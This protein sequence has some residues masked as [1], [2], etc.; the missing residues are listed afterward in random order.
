MTE[1]AP[2]LDQWRRL[3]QLAGRLKELAPWEWMEEIDLFGVQDPERGTLN[4]VG[5]MGLIKEHFAL[6]LYLGPQSLHRFIELHRRS[7][8]PDLEELLNT[9]QLQLSFEDRD[10]V[11]KEDRQVL[12]Q[13]GLS[14]RG[15]NS[16]PLWRSYRPG[17]LPWLI[18]AE[19]ARLL[20][21][22]IEQA[23]EVTPRFGRDP[24]LLYPGG[25]H[26][27]LVRVNTD[28]TWQDQY[29]Q[30]PPVPAS[31]ITAALD[32]FSLARLR[33][34]PRTAQVLQL[35]CSR[36]WSPVLEG[37]DRPYF[38]N[39]LLLVEAG[40]G[41]V[42]GFELLAPLPN[43]EE[44]WR[45][46]PQH[47]AQQFSQLGWLPAGI[48]LARPRLLALLQPMLQALDLPGDQPASLPALEAAKRF[49]DRGAQ[50]GF[51]PRVIPLDFDP[52]GG[53]G[54]NGKEG[55][56]EE[57][58]EEE[59]DGPI[60]V[61][62]THDPLEVLAQLVRSA[63]F[64]GDHLAARRDYL[65][66]LGAQTIGVQGPGSVL[67]DFAQ[68]L[69]ALKVEG[70]ELTN[71]HR[72]PQVRFMAQVNERLARPLVLIQKR[73][74][75]RSYPNICG[76]YL[77][78]RS[79]GLGWGCRGGSR[80]VLDPPVLQR[81][82]ALST[83][84]QYFTLLEGWLLRS[85][86]ALLDQAPD[87]IYVPLLQWLQFFVQIPGQGLQVAGHRYWEGQITG[88]PGLV[89]LALMESFG[90]L[91]TEGNSCLPGK[92]WRPQQVRRTSFGD[93]LLAR[94]CDFLA[95]Q[96]PPPA[97]DP[98]ACGRLQPIF[99]PCFPQW[100]QT[101]QVP[102]TP[103]TAG[104]YVFGVCLETAWRR[105]AAPAALTLDQLAGAIVK[106]FDFDF[107]HLYCFLFE[108][109]YGLP[110]QVNHPLVE[111][112]PFANQVRVGDV[113][114]QPGEVMSLLYDFGDEWEFMVLLERIDPPNAKRKK[115]AVLEKRGRAP[116]QYGEDFSF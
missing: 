59:E 106:A 20:E 57:E 99:Q 55:E 66:V 19:E 89:N 101:L 16:W 90:L 51:D 92:G 24:S 107:D 98:R 9:P 116:A 8:P 102:E 78:L 80:L 21:L 49:V 46:L 40:T 13:L 17:F 44:M 110:R 84:E 43:L 94:L 79:S 54:G 82:Q 25:E 77:L 38:P 115:A 2:T 28:R 58:E 31:Q 112:P 72:L 22:A 34:L 76:L 60:E 68:L 47:L 6:A 12:K 83:T 10:Q 36:F 5:I 61:G 14:F 108:D 87:S 74:Q 81:W 111:E 37:A 32:D 41:E 65:S 71:S 67:A 11:Q 85:S 33:Q 109:R 97:T 7:G 56:H 30:V 53:P 42:L 15:A 23:L 52:D 105:I 103:F 75:P 48:Q 29:L 70:V 91:Q 27:Y 63:E 96:P 114:L 35:D 62:L 69:E 50:A 4:F 73:P 64:G 45:T 86:P 100:Q 1:I 104:E 3:Y 113:P 88:T 26:R 39:M 18:D 93:A 95:T